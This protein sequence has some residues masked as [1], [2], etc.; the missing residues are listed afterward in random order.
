V[1]CVAVGAGRALAAAETRPADRHGGATPTA[2]ADAVTRWMMNLESERV[3]IRREGVDRDGAGGT[4]GRGRS[5]A[6]GR[7]GPDAATVEALLALE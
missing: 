7:V 1:T 4:D 6:S 5:T 3:R 2:L